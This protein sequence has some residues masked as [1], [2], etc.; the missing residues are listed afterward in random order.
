MKK[1]MKK[2][3]AQ[4]PM[5]RPYGAD[6]KR[7]SQS[8]VPYQRSMRPHDMR[9]FTTMDAGKMTPIGVAGL[10]RE[11]E[12]A[13]GNLM[14]TFEMHETAEI[15]MNAVNVKVMAYLV[16]MLALD[17]FVSMDEL[18]RSYAGTVART[19]DTVIPFIETTAF[20]AND[21]VYKKLGLHSK[22]GSRVNSAYLEAYNQIWNFRATNRS[23]NLDHR[24]RLRSTLAPA[25][26]NH[27]DFSKIVP[28]FDQAK[29]DGEVDLNIT[30]PG[31]DIP[32]QSI[33]VRGIGTQTSSGSGVYTNR[34][35]KESGK[36]SSTTYRYAKQSEDSW[37]KMA[38]S[39]TYSLPEIY[40]EMS[41]IQTAG[42]SRDASISLSNLNLAKQTQAFARL[43]EQ[44]AGYEDDVDE[45]VIDLLMEGINVPEQA[46]KHPI[47]LGES[48]AVF[49]QAK[50]Y[51]TDSGNL[52]ESA[53]N[54]MAQVSLNIRTPQITCGGVIM[55]V[56]EIV[57]EQ[58]WERKSDPFLQA[59]LV[60]DLPN[61]LEDYLDPTKVE[62]VKNSYVDVSHADSDDIFGYA[63]LNH[64]W[65][66]NTPRIGG[67]FHKPLPT[68]AFN[69]N[70][71]RIWAS[72]TVDPVLD[73]DFYL[74]TSLTE[75]IFASTTRDN[76]EVLGRGG[77]MIRGNT[78]FGHEVIEGSDDYEEVIDQVDTTVP[79]QT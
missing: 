4:R 50:R 10:L 66:V 28:S 17:R 9:H 58:L 47:L 56:A 43:R 78:Q 1:P 23:P 35:V 7:L 48:S 65:A 69:E 8:A 62:V 70:R 75:N 71:Q 18:N 73:E 41:A 79:D 14:Y 22:A 52:D 57:P 20:N 26:W 63:P 24:S 6:R 31:I 67:D 42:V 46:L 29:I 3:R 15:L 13:S 77:L 44:Y 27:A 72:E 59:K 76:F 33:P 12:V 2:K 11:D 39:A 5:A 30:I 38:S 49:G 34:G 37:I 55:I 32:A 54:G 61:A 68:S 45:F 74:T 36:T 21:H 51:A 40:A 16:P 25:F 64:Q 19:G 53:V 60:S